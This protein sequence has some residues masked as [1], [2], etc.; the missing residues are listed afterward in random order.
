[1][2][3]CQ[4]LNSAVD[5]PLPEPFIVFLS[6]HGRRADPFSAVF[7]LQVVFGEKEV[8]RAGFAHGIDAFGA[9][10]G[11]LVNFASHVHVHEIDRSISLSR[12]SKGAQTGFDRAPIQG[13]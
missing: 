3:G 2:I 5:Q 10:I 7:S 13:G 11:E 1:M 8:L 4:H 6:A 12:Q 9:G